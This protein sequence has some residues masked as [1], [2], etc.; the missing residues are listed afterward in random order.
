M[1]LGI[2]GT[3]T[4]FPDARPS[5]AALATASA[6]CHRNFGSAFSLSSSGTPW[7]W[8][9]PVYTGPGHNVAAVT[10]VPLS[11]SRI[12]SVYDNTNALAAPYEAWPGTGPKAPTDATLSTAP[13][14]RL[15]MLGT[16]RQ[17]RSTTA[18]T[19]TSTRL[20]AASGLDPATGPSV[21]SPAL[22]TRMSVTT[23]SAAT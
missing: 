15:T 18:A 13:R 23:P 6:C 14:P 22:L 10:P 11:S 3:I 16:N 4:P 9:N 17:H 5:T 21:A 2:P 19:S 7:T 8:R 1:R 12:A 20:S